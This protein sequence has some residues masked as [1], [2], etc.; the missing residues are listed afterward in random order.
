MIL[1]RQVPP[2]AVAGF[3][4]TL[5]ECDLTLWGRRLRSN[6][7]EADH[8]QCPL[9]GLRCER[10]SRRAAKER[11][12]LAPLNHSITSSA[13]TSARLGTV[14]PSALA[15]LTLSTVSNL[16]GCCTGRSAGLSPLR[17]RPAYSPAW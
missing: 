17:M 15:V 5:A 4:Q 9:L 8:R 13:R 10:P 16:T 6:A 7:D 3:A 2:L 1:D 12:E 11:D 14:R